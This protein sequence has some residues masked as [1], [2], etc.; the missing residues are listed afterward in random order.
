MRGLFDQFLAPYLDG[1]IEVL[2]LLAQG[3][4]AADAQRHQQHH[5]ED[6][7]HLLADAKTV[8]EGLCCHIACP[9]AS[10]RARCLNSVT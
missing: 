1:I 5:H 8:A 3:E 10:R 4:P 7:E 2:L 6:G 9:G